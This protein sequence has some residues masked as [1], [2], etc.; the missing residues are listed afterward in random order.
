M[1]KA[2]VHAA[3]IGNP[4]REFKVAEIWSK[5]I[6]QEFFYQGDRERVLGLDIS[7]G[8]DRHTSNFAN[9]QIGFIGF[10]IQPYFK[11]LSQVLPLWQCAVD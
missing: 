10:M 4:T 3:D 5:K 7:F 9:S 2:V 6:V 11:L 8:C 1:L